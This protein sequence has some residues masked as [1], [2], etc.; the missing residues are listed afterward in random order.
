MHLYRL[1]ILLT[2]PPLYCNMI[3]YLF[4]LNFVLFLPANIFLWC[5]ST[6]FLFYVQLKSQ[7]SFTTIRHK[8]RCS[9]Y[10]YIFIYSYLNFF[11][12]THLLY[13]MT[14]TKL[15]K[16]GK[17]RRNFLD[18]KSMSSIETTIIERQSPEVFYK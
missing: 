4:Q 5:Y 8:F 2:V 17:L 3:S 15:I 11:I 14:L 10:T 6:L 16:Y 7:N 13:C 12:H 9:V 1:E 18:L